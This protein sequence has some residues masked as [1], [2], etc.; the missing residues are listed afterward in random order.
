MA[1][2]GRIGEGGREDWGGKEGEEVGRRRGLILMATSTCTYRHLT[3]DQAQVGWPQADGV[4]HTHTAHLFSQHWL[5]KDVRRVL[6]CQLVQQP[7]CDNSEWTETQLTDVLEQPQLSGREGGR[8]GGGEGRKEKRGKGERKRGHS[9]MHVF[10]CHM[11]SCTLQHTIPT[12]SH[13]C[14]HAL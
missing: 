14:V 8:E 1:E 11:L 5:G 9:N 3:T 6:L 2:G 12:P 10:I 13:T 7:L 4:N